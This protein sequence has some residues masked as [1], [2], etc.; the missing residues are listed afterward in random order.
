MILYCA[1]TNLGKLRE[2]RKAAE[3]AL[4]EVQVVPGLNAIDAP[5]ETGLTFE[6]NAVLKAEIGRAHV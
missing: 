3:I 6:S 4:C 5:D 2:F 1:T